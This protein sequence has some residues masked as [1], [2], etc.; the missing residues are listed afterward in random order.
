MKQLITSLV[1]LC[2][3][4]VQAQSFDHIAYKQEVNPAY[5]M[6]I[7][8]KKYAE[9][10]QKLEAVNKKYGMLYGEDYRLQAYC[11]K[12]T[13]NNSLAAQALKT[14]WSS[15]SFDMRTLWY[16]A[17]L[18]PGKIMEG[19]TEAEN[20]LVYEGFDNS[21]KIRPKNADSL[22]AVIDSMTYWDQFFRTRLNDSPY[23][24]K[25]ISELD[26]MNLVNEALLEKM[27]RNIGFPGE[28][29]LQFSEISIWF[30]LVHTAGN[31]SFYER[32]KPVFLQEVRIGNM[33]PWIFANWADQH[34]FYKKL[35]TIYNTQIG[36]KNDFT[37]KELEE[38]TKN[39]FE[40]GLM[41]LEFTLYH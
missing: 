15:L 14:S 5:E 12:M 3:S 13:G 19:F 37:K 27:V 11:Y 39:R 34:Q 6:A 18:D 36:L 4:G 10:L 33:S 17:P 7:K 25:A 16:V 20:A 40:I 8:E 35:P 26:S 1:L 21:A 30:V 31:E 29:K 32:M 2:M 28:K 24:Q 22:I 38:I 23:D 41:D 9:S